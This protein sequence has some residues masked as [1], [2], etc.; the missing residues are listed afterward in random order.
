MAFIFFHVN[1][2]EMPSTAHK[3]LG[4]CRYKEVNCLT[5]DR[6]FF[7]FDYNQKCSNHNRTMR[8]LMWMTK[9]L[10]SGILR[11]RESFYKFY[12]P[13]VVKSTLEIASWKFMKIFQMNKFVVGLRWRDFK[14][15]SANFSPH[16]LQK[17]QENP[18]KHEVNVMKK[19][20]NWFL[21]HFSINIIFF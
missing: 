8:C 15:F 21:A 14:N 20:K 7:V 12:K 16:Q 10:R 4:S 5:N 3:T 13:S 17:L 9:K 2:Q 6:A 19:L 1:F 18:S 11:S